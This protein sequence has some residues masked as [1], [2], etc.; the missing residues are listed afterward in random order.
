MFHRA[1]FSQHNQRQRHSHSHVFFVFEKVRHRAFTNPR[2]LR[3][4]LQALDADK[5]GQL[6]HEELRHGLEKLGL[7]QVGPPMGLEVACFG[8]EICV[9]FGC[10]WGGA[11]NLRWDSLWLLGNDSCHLIYDL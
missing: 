7:R 6:D 5:S 9:S 10:F 4:R 1:L 11:W 8:V 2:K 3:V